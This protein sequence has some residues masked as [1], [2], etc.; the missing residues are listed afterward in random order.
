MGA[1]AEALG[2]I[3]A[4]ATLVAATVAGALEFSGSVGP[5]T[6]VAI[7]LGAPSVM[8]LTDRQ[9]AA[10]SLDA[11]PRIP[12][13]RVLGVAVSPDLP[14]A[15]PAPKAKA[16]VE[17]ERGIGISGN[18]I[19]SGELGENRSASDKNDLWVSCNPESVV[20]QAAC[21]TYDV[22]AGSS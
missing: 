1:P 15:G 16:A 21:N 17:V 22:V 10:P 7:R 6:P 3:I 8:S 18:S 2:T 11:P 19:V 20:K 12:S 4:A 14:A 13:A 5:S 9:T